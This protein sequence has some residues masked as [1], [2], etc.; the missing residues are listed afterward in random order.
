MK[1]LQQRILDLKEALN[2]K[3][4]SVNE[5]CSMYHETSQKIRAFNTTTK[6]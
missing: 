5:Y 6:G 3:L 2:A 4:I 1:E